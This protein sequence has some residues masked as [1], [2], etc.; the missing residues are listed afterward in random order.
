MNRIVSWGE[1][2]LGLRLI[3]KQPILSLTIVLALATGICLATMGFTFRDQ[4]LN[5]KLP[6]KAG[7]R[8]ARF[9]VLN[10]D[11]GRLDLDLE[12]YHTLRDRATTFEHIGAAGGRPF[13]VEHES[14]ELEQIS[15]ALITPRTMKWLD[16]APMLGRT[17]IPEDGEQGAEPV[18]LLR[19]SL[20]RRRYSS[21]PQVVGQ[22]ITVGG[23]PR[24]VVGI[25]PDTF[26]FPN[27]GELWL[28]LD[29]LALGNRNAVRNRVGGM[30][31][32]LRVIGVIK[33]G[34]TFEAAT[35]E[36]NALA[37][38]LPTAPPP[39][40]I[41]RL[42]VLPFTAELSE[43]ETVMSAL[44][45][46]LVMV[47]LVVASNV[48]TLVFARTWAR[49]PELAVRTALGAARSRV[50]G[51]LFVET[52]LL[53][54]IAAVMGL[55]GAYAALRY[56]KGS[57]EGWPFWIV[58]DPNPRIVAFVVVLTLIVAMIAGLFPALKVTRHDLRNALQAGRGFAFGGFG[59][60]GAF[61]LVVEIALSV[62]LLNGAVTMARAFNAN[63]QDIPALSANQVLTVWLYK[64]CSGRIAHS[65]I[66]SDMDR[67]RG[68][69][70]H[71]GKA[72]FLPGG[73]E[74]GAV[75]R[76][77]EGGFEGALELLGILLWRHGGRQ[78]QA[79]RRAIP[80]SHPR[81]TAQCARWDPLRLVVQVVEVVL[82]EGVPMN[83]AQPSRS[84]RAGLTTSD[85]IRGRICAYSSKTAPS[86]YRP[87]RASGLSAP[88]I[89]IRRS[90]V[91][92][93]RN[94]ASL[95]FVPG[96]GRVRC[97]SRSQ[98]MTFP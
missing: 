86:R 88:K 63:I 30:V 67:G 3:V 51:Q 20:W 94:S 36:A 44:V 22:R 80:V 53:G 13:T 21:D 48:A 35:T 62:A 97:L 79:R 14:G 15:G 42:V 28:P 72:L 41:A 93:T 69:P 7:D 18:V 61:L 40:D 2:R 57:F 19:E 17:L 39:D 56:I 16:A 49:A 78:R 8:F 58:L 34:A 74:V 81:G 87:R 27:S 73:V 9:I 54:S 45:F 38:P 33:S 68:L 24:A 47:L 32:G 23:Q 4:L 91:R 76:A 46:V 1:V 29:E 75:V 90:P 55:A 95:I 84:A 83:V 60:V 96:S 12:R 92:S 11:G 89:C 31:P 98:A 77:D 71:T 6:Y 59:K 5:S 43:A 70:W 52:L 50:V 85:H 26:E 66:K 10:R 37:S 64:P 82:P 65:N 25:M